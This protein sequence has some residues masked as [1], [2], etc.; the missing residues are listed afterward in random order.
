MKKRLV[1]YL[2]A[3]ALLAACPARADYDETLSTGKD[4]VK[5]MS[6]REK[7]MSLIPPA[8]LFNEYDIRLRHSLPQYIQWMD[9]IL[10]STPQLEKEDV[11]NIFASTVYL[12]EPEN[13][14]ALRAMET[15]YLRGDYDRK[16][17]APRLTI[18]EALREITQG[19]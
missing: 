16:I 3:L 9:Y 18:E 12:F 8:L 11:S 7:F 10:L 1:I 2:S 17:R 13:R 5:H 19:A 15:N 4:W 6:P 14:E